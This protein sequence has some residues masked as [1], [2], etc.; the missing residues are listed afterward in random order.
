MNASQEIPR[1]TSNGGF[2][3]VPKSSE[4]G[5]EGDASFSIIEHPHP[6]RAYTE[7]GLVSRTHYELLT[8]NQK[9]QQGL[10][11]RSLADTFWENDG[12]APRG[13]PSRTDDDGNET[14]RYWSYAWDCNRKGSALRRTTYSDHIPTATSS[15]GQTWCSF[16]GCPGEAGTCH[17][18][19][20][21]DI[22]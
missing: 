6:A 18:D 13:G 4:S 11:Q 21:E 22:H 12:L 7:W 19:R 2:Q 10:S 20:E 14:K 5:A 15:H 1:S 3:E 8:A 9:I 17:T 16:E